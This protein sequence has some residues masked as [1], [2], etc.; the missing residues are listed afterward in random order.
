MAVP[1]CTARVASM[2]LGFELSIQSQSG[3]G[4]SGYW[5]SRFGVLQNSYS[6]RTF[7]SGVFDDKPAAE[8]R[9]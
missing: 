9:I 4:V 8:A 5:V 3:G 6:M 2:A 7:S 1:L